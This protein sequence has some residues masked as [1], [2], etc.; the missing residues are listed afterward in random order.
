MLTASISLLASCG[1]P[2]APEPTRPPES[3]TVT[4]EISTGQYAS[5]VTNY[6]WIN[7]KTGDTI[8]FD[9]NGTFKGKLDK[10]SYKGTFTLRASKKKAGVVYSNVTLDGKK[11]SKEWTFTFKDTAHMTLK[12]DKKASESYAAEWTLEKSET[13]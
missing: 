11:K 3:I 13:K 1:C 12:T 8:K 10:K 7:E 6:K 2:G 5:Y 4:P 9:S